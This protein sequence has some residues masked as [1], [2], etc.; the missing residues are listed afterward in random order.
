M[1]KISSKIQEQISSGISDEVVQVSTQL[2]GF[3]DSWDGWHRTLE[4]NL[5]KVTIYFSET[6]KFSLKILLT[7]PKFYL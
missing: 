7:V 2:K 4:N 6:P 3:R 5:K 1:F